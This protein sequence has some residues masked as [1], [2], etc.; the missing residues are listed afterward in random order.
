MYQ[1]ILTEFQGEYKTVIWQIPFT[2][3]SGHDDRSYDFGS[4]LPF[5][6]N[7]YCQIVQSGSLEVWKIAEYLQRI[8]RNTLN[9]RENVPKP[10]S[11]HPSCP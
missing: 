4:Q 7:C 2:L 5:V 11:L 6:T 10:E 1:S 9:N 8:G 3:F